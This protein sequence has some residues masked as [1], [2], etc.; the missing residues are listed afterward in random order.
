MLMTD[1]EDE[2]AELKQRIL[3]DVQHFGG[4]LPERNA[5]RLARLPGC[6]AG[7]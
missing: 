6:V 3:A 1:T 4:A 7:I 2:Q 5:H